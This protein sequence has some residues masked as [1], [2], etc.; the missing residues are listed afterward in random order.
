MGG[1]TAA[2]H[3]RLVAPET[4]IVFISSHYTAGDASL[5][6]RLLGGGAFVQKAEPGS[7]SFK[8]DFISCELS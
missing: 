2:Y 5:V 7:I 4:K 1:V 3:I 6:T 8:I